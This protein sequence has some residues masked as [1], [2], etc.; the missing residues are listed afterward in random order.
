MSPTLLV[1]FGSKP[2]GGR[3][4]ISSSLMLHLGHGI[5]EPPQVDRRARLPT[6][7][8]GGFRKSSRSP[9]RLSIAWLSLRALAGE[10]GHTPLK[11]WPELQ[12]IRP[13]IATAPEPLPALANAV[14]QETK[15]PDPKDENDPQMPLLA[16]CRRADAG[17]L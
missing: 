7:S 15:F 13:P 12:A 17:L 4:A 11:R 3:R 5:P 14:S 9:H 2:F 10:G 8:P 16:Y 1:E 6:V